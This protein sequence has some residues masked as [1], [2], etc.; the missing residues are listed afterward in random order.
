MT[1]EGEYF[2]GTVFAMYPSGKDDYR[3]YFG[4]YDSGG[5]P[6]GGLV[7]LGDKVF[8]TGEFGGAD[9][10]G[11]V[12]SLA[13]GEHGPRLVHAFNRDS[14]GDRPISGLTVLGTKLYGV[15]PQG[16]PTLRG[17]VYEITP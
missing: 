15:T 17:T 5:Y 13:S 1:R 3:W 14:D 9:Q 2:G 16:G 8:G 6:S 10:G 12:V 7:E 11:V 4:V